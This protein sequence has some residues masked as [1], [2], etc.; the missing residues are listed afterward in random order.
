MPLPK[1]KQCDRGKLVE[2][3]NTFSIR[4]RLKSH[5]DGFPNTAPEKYPKFVEK[6]DWQPP[7][8]GRDLETFINSVESYITNN[9]PQTPKHDNLKPLGHSAQSSKERIHNNKAFR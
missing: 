2:D 9:K 6:S 8:Q 4:M 7:K 3:S 5:S 1:I